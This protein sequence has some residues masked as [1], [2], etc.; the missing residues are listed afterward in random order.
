V[1]SGPGAKAALLFASFGSE[2]RAVRCD[3]LMGAA[4]F[5]RDE[6]GDGLGQPIAAEQPVDD[7]GETIPVAFAIAVVAND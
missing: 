6:R 7:A 3:R 4:S 1:V 2:A 5:R